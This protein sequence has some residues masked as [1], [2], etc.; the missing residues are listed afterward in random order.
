MSESVWKEEVAE[1]LIP[2]I[3]SRV[4]VTTRG[5]LRSVPA[6]V[7]KPEEK[8]KDEQYPLVSIY[9]LYDRFSRE[10]YNPNPQV[11]SREE[12]IAT[13]EKPCKP[14]DL[15]YQIDFWSKS[16][17]HMTEMTESWLSECIPDFVLKVRD[18]SNI[19][20]NSY[21]LAKGDIKRSDLLSG[22]SRIFHSFITYRISVAID[23]NV[24]YT[25]P[26]V[27]TVEVV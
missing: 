11:V 5:V 1:A 16:E 6:I 21:V 10:R 15:F 3:Q 24:Q 9:N 25:T 2:F 20:R 12:G 18:K 7:R 8:F 19:E 14:F 27:T 13:I 17:I 23:N 26:Y 4:K 22:S